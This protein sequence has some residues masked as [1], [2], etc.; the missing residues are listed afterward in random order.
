MRV[1]T[2]LLNAYSRK[3]KETVSKQN[4]PNKISSSNNLNNS[5]NWNKTNNSES[6][7]SREY[8]TKGEHLKTKL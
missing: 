8:L 7:S 5:S 3:S 1:R 4:K 2:E 6:Y